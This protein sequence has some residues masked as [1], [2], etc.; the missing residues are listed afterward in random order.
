VSRVFKSPQAQALLR[1]A[2][3]E[4]LA[5]WP[6]PHEQL[7]LSTREGE[8]FVI[9][10]GPKTAPPVILL[11]GT[12]SNSMAWIR[13]VAHWS[14]HFRVHAVDIIGDAGLSAPSRPAL[15]SEAHALWLD[16]VLAA[17]GL[18][19]A[20]FVGMSF[21]GWLALDY[22]VRRPE[23][24]CSLA[25]LAPGGIG[26][27]KAILF[28]ALPLLMLGP[29]G[30]RRVRRR[31]MGRPRAHPSP[32][33][34]RMTDFMALPFRCMTPRTESLPI[35]DDAALKNL[36]MPLLVVLGGRDVM[37]DSPGI[38]ERIRRCVQGAQIIYLPEAPHYLGDQSEPVAEFLGRTA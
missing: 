31:I 20:A 37:V 36:S 9:V 22:A 4:M 8:T 24:V 33:A 29:W 16:D 5:L 7:R 19:R 35:V 3:R 26:R 28:W 6:V 25:L 2:Y 30:V 1:K 13:E 11:H 23:R 34:K 15:A 10:C 14:P 12:M 27:Q 18:E 38:R 32:A 17:L 21:G